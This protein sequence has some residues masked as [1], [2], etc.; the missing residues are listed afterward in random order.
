MKW[1]PEEWSNMPI[2][3]VLI[4]WL[5]FL[6]LG[7]IVAGMLLSEITGELWIP[8]LGPIQVVFLSALLLMLGMVRFLAREVY[9][10]EDDEEQ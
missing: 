7:A 10:A 6:F 9:S 5:A 1:A 2:G 4:Y 8:S 3:F